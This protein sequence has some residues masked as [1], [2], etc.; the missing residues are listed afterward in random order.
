MPRR[1]VRSRRPSRRSARGRKTTYGRR[2]SYRPQA[3]RRGVFRRGGMSRKRILNITSRKKRNGMLCVTNAGT[4]GT[5][6][7]SF[8]NAALYVNG[9]SGGWVLWAATA[10]NLNDGSST[11]GT[12]A[13]MA[14]RTATTCYMRG[15]S[16]NIKIQTSSAIPWFWR[17]IV[18]RLKGNPNFQAY[19]SAP[20]T[21]TGPYYDS[22]AGVERLLLNSNAQ[23][24]SQSAQVSAQ[25]S[26]LFKGRAG[27]DWND[28]LIA[29]VDT[30]RV[31]LMYDKTRTIRSGNQAGA[32]LETKLFHPFNKNLVYDDDES[33]ATEETSFYSTQS[34]A[35]MGDVYV[36]DQ[37]YAGAG[38][39]ATDLLQFSTSSTLYW[40]ER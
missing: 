21:L 20:P 31:T 12:I 17:R 27:V 35:G 40:H 18:F 9:S 30:A 11:L 1:T 39:S 37:L 36:L 25:Q 13:E 15:L 19:T 29:P 24:V 6:T 34:K 3:G 28:P 8:I 23:S 33:G 14:Q 22:T 26:V 16:E 38:A 10:Q 32:L 2:R 4:T 7:S 5:S